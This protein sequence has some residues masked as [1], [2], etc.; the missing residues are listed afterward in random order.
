MMNK[1]GSPNTAHTTNKVPCF[2][3]NSQYKSIQEGR[4]SDVAPS[5]LKIMGIAK[6]S[7]M[8]GDSLIN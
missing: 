5:I 7:E 1:D 8:S 2:I 3:V 4:L 6:P